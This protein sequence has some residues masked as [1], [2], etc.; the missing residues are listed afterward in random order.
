MDGMVGGAIEPPPRE[1]RDTIVDGGGPDVHENEGHQVHHLV[2]REEHD[3]DVVGEALR[4]TVHGMERVAGER[5]GVLPLVVG[6]VQRLVPD[7]SATHVESGPRSTIHLDRHVQDG[8]VQQAVHPV[9][10]EIGEDEEPDQVQGQELPATIVLPRVLLSWA[11]Q[12]RVPGSH[13]RL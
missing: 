6:L 8:V 1:E 7:H 9:D 11:I 3:V 5:R 10:D 13:N 2:H 12:L 4:P